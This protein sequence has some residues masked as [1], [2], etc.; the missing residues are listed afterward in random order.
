[1]TKTRRVFFKTEEVIRK[2]KMGWMEVEMDFV[3]LYH[4]AWRFVAQLSG[5]CSR[6]FL[7]WVL[8]KID[9][10]NTFVYSR[11]LYRDFVEDLKKIN[12]GREYEENTVHLALREFIDKGIAVKLARGVYQLNPE[13]FWT[14]E[15]K[16]RLGAINVSRQ[17][18]EFQTRGT[19]APPELPEAAISRTVEKV[20]DPD[21]EK[22]EKKGFDMGGLFSMD[23]FVD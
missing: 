20:H 8:S 7:L 3:Q 17:L 12:G 22:L 16:D 6:D 9:E 19:E 4:N 23:S 13:I 10:N 15:I 11:S 18:N 21:A 1:M 5:V 14:G 2:T